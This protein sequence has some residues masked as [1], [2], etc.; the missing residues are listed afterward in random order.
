MRR[1]REEV[2]LGV[3]VRALVLVLD[4]Q[5][6]GS[7]ERDAEL[8]ARLD[9]DGVCFITLLLRPPEEG[10]AD[11]SVARFRASSCVGQDTCDFC[12][13]PASALTG[14][15]SLLW[16]GRRRDIC[17][18]MSASLSWRPCAWMKSK[19]AHSMRILLGMTPA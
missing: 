16:P 5:S 15:V 17:F 8:C 11:A 4:A 7:A 9:G 10:R 1:A 13:L 19:R 18:W 2:G 3:V 6:D 14:V 12:I